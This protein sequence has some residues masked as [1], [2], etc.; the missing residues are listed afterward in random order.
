MRLVLAT[1][2]VELVAYGVAHT[3]APFKTYKKL[4]ALTIAAIQ[5]GQATVHDDAC[6][7]VALV[8]E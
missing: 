8:A 1:Y 6:F 3:E 4:T 5:A 2:G 7:G